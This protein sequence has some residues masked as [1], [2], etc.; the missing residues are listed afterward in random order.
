MT[1]PSG[2]VGIRE[3]GGEDVGTPPALL[4]DHPQGR[5]QVKV[6]LYADPLPEATRTAVEE[7]RAPGRLAAAV[8][9]EAQAARGPG[10]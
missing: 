2:R 1:V 3:G 4:P 7:G 10:R 5:G 9:R 6:Q 8:L